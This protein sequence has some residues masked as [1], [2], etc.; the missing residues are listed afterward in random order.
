MAGGP[1]VAEQICDSSSTSL[2]YLVSFLP[3]LLRRAHF[4]SG[5][6]RE[7][8]LRFHLTLGPYQGI[9]KRCTAKRAQ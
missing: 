3:Q 8:P 2:G 7:T 1:D 5:Q 9:T 6:A 4:S